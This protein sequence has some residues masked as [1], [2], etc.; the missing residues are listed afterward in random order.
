MK[1]FSGIAL[2]ILLSALSVLPL[3]G[4]GTEKSENYLSIGLAECGYGREWLD[5]A[6]ED[7][8]EAYAEKYPDLTWDVEADAGITSKIATR[9]DTSTE[10]CDIFIGLAT[11]W[12]YIPTII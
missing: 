8:K 9:L 12:Q 10:L 7:F 11:S 3:A 1:K 4:C 2:A 5:L 6:L